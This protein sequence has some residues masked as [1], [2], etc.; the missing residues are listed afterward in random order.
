MIV[1]V[2]SVI[3]RRGQQNKHICYKCRVP[4]EKGEEIIKDL[5]SNNDKRIYHIWCCPI[6]IIDKQI[7]LWQDSKLL[8]ERMQSIT[9]IQ[10]KLWQDS[11][12]QPR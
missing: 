4:I 1:I 9:D 11:K 8:Q 5:R 10:I 3:P 12:S 6:S 2:K 7:K